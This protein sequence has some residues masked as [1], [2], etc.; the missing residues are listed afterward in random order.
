MSGLFDRWM[1]SL[2]DTA[3]AEADPAEA[4]PSADAAPE[5]VET[6]QA[7]PARPARRPAPPVLDTV[8]VDAVD[9]ARSAITEVAGESEV[10]AHL[11]AV[12]EGTRLVTHSFACTNP[13]YRGWHWI[14]VLAR[15]PRS[16]KATVC[17]TALL[18]GADALVSPAWVPWE[19][20]L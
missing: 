2:T 9:V 19:E 5:A 4:A 10:G 14:A 17:E 8:L 16:K 7:A 11:G 15:A 20:R 1:A 12:A 13:A 18:P 6:E 3:P